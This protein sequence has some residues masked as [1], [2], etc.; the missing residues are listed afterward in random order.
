MKHPAYI[1]KVNLVSCVTLFHILDRVTISKKSKKYIYGNH[2]YNASS[3]VLNAQG[4]SISI[5]AIS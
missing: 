3:L 1:L 4:V 5:I 2:A